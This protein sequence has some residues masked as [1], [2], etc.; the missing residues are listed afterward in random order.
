[1]ARA[2]T[3]LRPSTTER[4]SVL[5]TKVDNIDVK[6][7]ELKEDVKDMHDCLDRTRD[8]IMDKLEIMNSSYEKNR[9]LYYAHADKLHQEQTAQHHELAGKISELEKFKNKGTMYFMVLLAFLAGAGWLGHMDL[10]KIIK[11]VGL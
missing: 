4:V 2:A 1:M 10:A 6:I 3:A 7:C 11:F 8:S 5:E 9:D